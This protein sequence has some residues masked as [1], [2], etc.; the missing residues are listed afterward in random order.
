MATD[1][2]HARRSVSPLWATNAALQ[3]KV[4]RLEAENLK[5]YIQNVSMRFKAEV[6]KEPP[7]EA[8]TGKP[9]RNAYQRE[10]M[11]KKRAA[12]KAAKVATHVAMTSA[13][14]QKAYRERVKAK[15]AKQPLGGDGE[16]G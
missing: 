2:D 9:N 7:R 1:H 3:A 8:S 12:D 4:N 15:A 11:R 10:W 13:E 14:R 5:L 16:A 6:L